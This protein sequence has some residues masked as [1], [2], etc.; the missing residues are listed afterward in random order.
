MQLHPKKHTTHKYVTRAY[1]HVAGSSKVLLLQHQLH[2]PTHGVV[3]TSATKFLTKRTIRNMPFEKSAYVVHAHR[4]RSSTAEN[5][6]QLHEPGSLQLL[7]QRWSLAHPVQTVVSTVT[8]TAAT[9]VLLDLHG[10]QEVA[11]L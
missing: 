6:Q 4:A 5:I 10:L 2:R 11:T 8:A 3:L 9:A 1:L 7:L